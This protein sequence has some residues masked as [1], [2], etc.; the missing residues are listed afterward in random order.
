MRALAQH[1]EVWDSLV[2][3]LKQTATVFTH[4]KP[5]QKHGYGEML[6]GLSGSSGPG[7]QREKR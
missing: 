6:E 1:P 2:R 3:A 4:R 5:T 7:M